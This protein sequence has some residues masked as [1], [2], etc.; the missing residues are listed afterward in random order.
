MHT[1]WETLTDRLTRLSPH[2]LEIA[3][4]A[5][6]AGLD[7]DDCELVQIKHPDRQDDTPELTFAPSDQPDVRFRVNRHGVQR[8]T[9]GS[10]WPS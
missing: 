3:T 10:G 8:L 5:R 9:A 6:L 7:P 4:H 2:G 1:T